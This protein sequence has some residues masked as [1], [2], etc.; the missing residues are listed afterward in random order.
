MEE[1]RCGRRN[2]R[3]AVHVRKD[4]RQSDQ[5]GSTVRQAFLNCLDTEL[6][7]SVFC[8]CERSTQVSA[9]SIFSKCTDQFE[10]N[11]LLERRV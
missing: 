4:A 3:R 9:V 1:I 5:S 7:L 8:T 2:A 11:I 10:S 6:L